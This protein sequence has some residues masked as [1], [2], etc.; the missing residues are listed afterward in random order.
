MILK[1]EAEDK[2][3][4]NLKAKREYEVEWKRLATMEKIAR[5]GR[6]VLTGENADR[7]LDEVIST[8]IKSSRKQK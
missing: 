8:G 7:I 2:A 6:K 3:V 1:A 5:E 4:D